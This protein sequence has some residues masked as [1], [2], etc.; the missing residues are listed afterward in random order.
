VAYLSALQTSPFDQ[1]E[2][3]AVKET[4]QKLGAKFTMFD[5]QSNPEKQVQQCQDAIATQRYQAFVIKAVAGPSM[6]ACARQAVAQGIK[7]VA[8]DNP[9]GPDDTAEPQVEGI[10]GSVISVAKANGEAMAGITERACGDLDPCRVIFIYGPPAFDYAARARVAYKNALESKPSIQIVAEATDNFATD[11]AV[12]QARQLLAAHPDANVI[13]NDC[14]ECALAIQNWLK[15]SDYKGKV[16]INGAGG[17]KAGVAAIRAGT[18]FATTV[19]MPHTLGSKGAEMAI[20]AARG[21][22]LGDTNLPLVETFSKVGAQITAD[23]VDEYT[24]EW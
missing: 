15:S 3:R 17:S 10:T 13:Q 19:N 24:P 7:V 9:L 4:A 6:M 16:K 1:I 22:T 12:T 8:V 2:I 23:N 21:E 14:D 5:A 20:K 11:Q 18:Q